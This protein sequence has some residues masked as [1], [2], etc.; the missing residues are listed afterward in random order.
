MKVTIVHTNNKNQLLRKHQDDG[1]ADGTI[2][3]G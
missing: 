1:E 2:R 3:K